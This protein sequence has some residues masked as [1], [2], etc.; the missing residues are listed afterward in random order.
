MG[1]AKA[2]LQRQEAV[3]NNLANASTGGFRADTMSFRAVPVRAEGTA[4][5]RVAT[6]ESTSGFDVT[7]GPMIHT[8]RNLDIAVNGAGWIA[9]QSFDGVESYTRDGRLQVGADGVLQ[10]S[11]GRPVVG[12]GG[13][14]GIPENATVMIGSDGT[15]SA[16]TGNQPPVQV[17]QIKLVNPASSE[18][19]KGPDGLVRTLTGEAAQPDPSVRLVD[20]T[21]EGSN[22]NVVESMVGMIALARQFELQM[23]MIQTAEANDQKANQLLALK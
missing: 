12:D 23:K 9:V 10:T 6:L 1:G 22:V 13:P 16:R 7:A 11:S 2:M 3:S 14:I 18:I 5:T 15:V 8:G 21:L 20:G 17:G 4:T 19:T